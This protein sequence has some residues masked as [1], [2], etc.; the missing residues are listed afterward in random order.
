M[1]NKRMFLINIIGAVGAI[2]AFLLASQPCRPNSSRVDN[3]ANSQFAKLMASDPFGG[4]MVVAKATYWT[5]EP[6]TGND[7]LYEKARQEIETSGVSPGILEAK[8]GAAAE[9]Q[10]KSTI[11]QFRWGY[12]LRKNLADSLPTGKGGEDASAVFYSLTQAGDPHTYNFTRLRYLVSIRSKVLIQLGERLLKQD[13]N[14][15]PVK[16]HLI[17]DYAFNVGETGNPQSKARALDLCHQLLQANA[18]RSSYYAVLGMVY[19]MSYTHKHNPA[20]GMA[21]I[22]AD[23]KYI[24]LVDSVSEAAQRAHGDVA[25]IKADL[26]KDK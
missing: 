4:K 9:S 13:S 6:W 11:A 15:N 20:D 2:C 1:Q 8:Y 17:E 21:A 23:Q 5:A 7:T 19:E 12:A 16:L 25:E 26:A 14:D 10:P 22:A 18:N 3:Y 24:S